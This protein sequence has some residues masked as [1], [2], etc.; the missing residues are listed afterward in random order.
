MLTV[1]EALELVRRHARSLSAR[2]APLSELLGLR[3]AEDVTSAVDS[4]PFDKSVVDGFAIATSDRSPTLNVIELVTAGSVPTRAVG[5]GTTIRVMTGAPVPDGADAVV[6]W[7]DC[8]QVDDAT[9]R[10]PAAEA[11]PGS[12][13]LKR[14]ASFGAGQTVL[15][16]GKRLAALDIAL[17][18]EIGQAEV[19]AY[20]SPRVGVLPTGDELVEA[21]EPAGPG[22]IRNSNGPMLLAALAAA[23]ARGVDLGVAR[24]NPEDLREKVAR[25]LECDV[26]LVSGGV[27]AGVKDLVPGVLAELGV[28]QVFHQVRVKPG[29]PL[30]FGVRKTGDQQTLVFG[31]PGNPVSTLATFKLFVEPAL[32]VLAG[33][34]FAPPATR[35]AVLA[36][37]VKH[38]GQR[39]TYQPCRIR[40]E[41]GSRGQCVVEALDWKGSA[42]LATL[43]RSD[44]LAALPE[45]DYELPA[46]AEV[47][48]LML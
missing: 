36:A 28:E 41:E 39:P 21:H 19:A 16:R 6:K 25:G 35:R 32:A 8:E 48:V 43:T 44:C 4:P 47:E 15:A 3:L 27:S 9:I 12:C 10:N 24:D 37:A 31:L 29:K 42:D 30:W 33:A 17:L 1:A 45:G 18:A 13:V 20:P 38:R 40:S 26:L 46:G 5:H 22:Q 14:G 2:R 23:G 11:T 7:E 34:E